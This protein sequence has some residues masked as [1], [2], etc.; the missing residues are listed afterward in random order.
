MLPKDISI[1]KRQKKSNLNRDNDQIRALRVSYE[2]GHLLEKDVLQNP[3][4]QFKQ[5]FDYALE[6]EVLEANAMTLATCGSNGQ[7]S[8]RTVLLKEIIEEGYVF[9]TNY[10]SDKGV[11]IDKNNKVALLFFWKELERQVRIEGRVKKVSKEKSQEYFQSRPKGSQIGAWT[12]PQSQTVTRE[13]L[14]SLAETTQSKYADESVLPL[15]PFWGG[16]IVKPISFEFWQGRQNRLHDRIIYEQ[17]AQSK[18]VISRL[19]P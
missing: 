5:W 12:S 19:A 18:W 2:K 9:Y 3:F 17:N 16:Y 15:P 13:E 1:L 11:Q 8:A 14:D 6:S 10:N 7:P 4:D